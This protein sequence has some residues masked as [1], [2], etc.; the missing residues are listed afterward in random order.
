MKHLLLLRHAKS[1]W[2]DMRVQDFERPLNDRGR[3]AAPAMAEYLSGHMPLPDYIL[4]STAKRT[5]ETL[6][7][8]Q[9]VYAHPLHVEMTRNIYEAPYLAIL[10]MLHKIPADTECAMVIGHNP[11][12]EDLS[13]ALC[14]E[15]RR[16]AVDRF[17]I[18]YP[19][20]ACAHITFEDAQWAEIGRGKGFLQD[21]VRPKDVMED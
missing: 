4:C 6:G 1:S 2:A 5:R 15:G 20:A 3:K 18:K 12:M 14:G 21:F 11:G 16:K 13:A 10:D 7:F 8:V 9:A 17:N 19:T